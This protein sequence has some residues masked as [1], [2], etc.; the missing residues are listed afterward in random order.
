MSACQKGRFDSR[1]IIITSQFRERIENLW[2]NIE[3]SD[4]ILF[5]FDFVGR[6]RCPTALRLARRASPSF[7]NPNQGRADDAGGIAELM[8][9]DRRFQRIAE[10]LLRHFGHAFGVERVEV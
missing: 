2:V 5:A 7:S 4:C 9:H 3:K 1:T 6:A 10:D 8:F